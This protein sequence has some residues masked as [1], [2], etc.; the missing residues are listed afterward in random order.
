MIFRFRE[1][2]F[3]LEPVFSSY[4]YYSLNSS[5]KFW[6]SRDEKSSE[7]AVIEAGFTSVKS[8]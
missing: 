3:I 8:I 6:I 2:L 4:K 7:K 1:I 5:L